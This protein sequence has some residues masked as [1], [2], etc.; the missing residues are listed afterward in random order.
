L[1]KI[2]IFQKEYGK[3]FSRKIINM[4]FDKLHLG[5]FLLAF[6]IGLIYVY[7]TAAPKEIII[8]HPSPTNAGKVLYRKDDGNGG[9]TCFRYKANKSVCPIEKDGVKIL[10]QPMVEDYRS[11]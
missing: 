1:E 7:S 5:Y 4:F 8:K 9:E 11:Q 2:E 6:T 3:F 10:P